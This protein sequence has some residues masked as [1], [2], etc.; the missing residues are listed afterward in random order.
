MRPLEHVAE[1]R[2][3][4]R[5]GVVIEPPAHPRIGAE[6]EVDAGVVIGVERHALERVA[7]PVDHPDGPQVD[8]AVD[9]LPVERREQ[10]RR[11]GAIEAGVV[12]EEL[13][14]ARHGDEV[15][16]T[17]LRRRAACRAWCYLAGMDASIYL[18]LKAGHLISLFLW[19]GGLF[20]VYWMLRL[21]AHAPAASHEKLTLMERSIAL[22]AD[23]AA[24]VA[25]GTGLALVFGYP[26]GNLL[27]Q[28]GAGWMHI[29][30]TVVVLG[31]LPVHGMLR[32]RIKRYGMGDFKPVPSWLW[33]LFL[34]AITVIVILVVRGP[35][36]FAK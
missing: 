12:E 4:E 6:P 13:E 30:L 7:I 2:G 14:D 5:G 29:K 21:H 22:S 35:L 36:M 27:G 11:G 3:L 24:A 1:R 8:L 26:G 10:R 28:P 20:A 25:I 17:P 33:S 15:D 18:W 16:H 9:H 23:I 31:L 34:A 19:I 32:A